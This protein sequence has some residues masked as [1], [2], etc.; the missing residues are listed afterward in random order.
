M[1]VFYTPSMRALAIQLLIQY[2]DR[3]SYILEIFQRKLSSLLHNLLW[4]FSV[5]VRNN[6]E[7]GK[8]QKNIF[9]RNIKTKSSRLY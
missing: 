7:I 2:L 6:F 5:V 4:S 1:Y 3:S 9:E 8:K